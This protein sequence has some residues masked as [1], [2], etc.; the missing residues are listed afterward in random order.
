MAPNEPKGFCIRPPEPWFG[1]PT[2][3]ALHIALVEPEI[4][5]NTGNIARLCAGADIWLHLVEPLG[6][7]LSNKHLRRAGLDY[8]PSV[9]LCVHQSL[10]ALLGI[11]PIERLFLLSTKATRHYH[12]CEFAPG[13]VLVFGKETKGLPV[14]LLEHPAAHPLKI[15]ITG[16]VRSLNL[17]NACAIV[18]YEALRQLDYKPIREAKQRRS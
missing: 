17:S 7:E 3:E 9:Q 11:F 5:G 8:W 18:L 1:T 16:A 12:E 10:D 15:P 4:P 13:S 2:D 6:F 14:D